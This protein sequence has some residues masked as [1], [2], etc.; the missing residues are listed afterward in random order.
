MW[1]PID[2]GPLGDVPQSAVA[3]RVS[4]IIIDCMSLRLLLFLSTVLLAPLTVLGQVQSDSLRSYDL[5]EIVIGGEGRESDRAEQLF[6]VSLAD[7]ARQDAPDVAGTLRLLPGATVQT[8]SRGEA[9]VYVRASGER[10]VALFLD[11]APLN[12]AWDNR[13]DLSLVPANIIGGMTIEKGAV[14][15]AYGTNVSGGAVNLQSR[16]LQ[17]P[18]RLSEMTLQGG[19]GSSRQIRG[20]FANRTQRSSI[21]VGATIAKSGGMIV[22]RGADLPFEPEMT[23]RANS[24][25]REGNIYVRYDLTGDRTRWG[26]TLLHASAEKGVP[27]EGHLDPSMENVRY[28]RY[29]RWQNTMAILNAV[30]DRDDWRLSGT[31]WLNRFRQQIDNYSDVTY[32]QRTASQRDLDDAAGLRLIAESELGPVLV[33]GIHLVSISGHR[34]DDKELVPE[35]KSALRVRYRSVLHSTG[36]E[37]TS[38]PTDDGHWVFGATLDGMLTP[39]VGKFDDQDGFYAW[40]VNTEWVRSLRKDVS[41]YLNAGSKPRFPT[42]RELFGTALNRYIV[43]P[44][45]TPERSWLAEGALN[46]TREEWSIGGGVFIQRTIGTIDQVNVQ[47]DGTNKR[48]R[49]NLDGSRVLGIEMTGSLI[50]SRRVRLE[51]HGTWLRPVAITDD[52]NR[53]LTE[54]PELLATLTTRIDVTGTLVLHADGVFTGRSYG[55]GIENDQIE[56]PTTVR[57]NLRLSAARYFKGSNVFAQVYAGINNVTDELHLSQLGLPDEGRSVRF[58]LNLSR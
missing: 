44:D 47:V 18:G 7:L 5:S 33:R 21:L 24:D 16:R 50:A 2:K 22:P 20:L 13:I 53:H 57:L 38:R 23:R 40:S 26:F 48:K 1:N 55:L 52:G 10:Q 11:G 30:S 15:A 6:R 32:D 37:I 36:M 43:N 27:P 56:L 3:F 54:K 41:L 17:T 35:I 46:L 49:I 58:G 31:A 12:I 39:E 45:L 28:W 14:G 4:F 51:G 29:P 25:R 42:M 34:Q 9:L 19:S 8:N